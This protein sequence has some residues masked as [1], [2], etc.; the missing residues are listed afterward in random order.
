[1]G[2]ALGAKNAAKA[3]HHN[4]VNVQVIFLIRLSP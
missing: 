4:N 1:M 3:A 2:A